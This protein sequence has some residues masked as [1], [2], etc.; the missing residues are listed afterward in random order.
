[1][2]FGAQ[3]ADS[4]NLVEELQD[5]NYVSDRKDKTMKLLTTVFLNVAIVFAGGTI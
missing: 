4:S 5:P 3:R 2:S 1:M